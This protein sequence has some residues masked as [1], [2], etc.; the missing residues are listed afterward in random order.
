MLASHPAAVAHA[1]FFI[2][3]CVRSGTTM[4]RNLLRLHPNLA[5]PEESHF[6]R[7]SEPFAAPGYVQAN[8]QGAVLKKHREMDGISED[9]FQQM[10]GAATSRADLCERYMRRYIE[11]NKPA[12]RRWFDKTPQNAYGAA[13]I[14]CEFPQAKFVHIVRD[15]VDVVASLRIGKVI[16][17]SNLVAACAY[18]NEAAENLYVLRKAFPERVLDIRYDSFTAQPAAG[19]AR[20][21][22]FLG[23]PFE[24]ATFAEVNT[25]TI[26][27]EEGAV[28]TREEADRVRQLCRQG[29]RWHGFGDADA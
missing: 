8:S 1:P 24:P 28:L 4:L 17:I 14:A 21:L 13:M 16:K 5:C 9:A 27:H 3:G 23:E 19:L 6:F 25:Q 18:W 7:W 12:A 15:P 29:R 10:L 20:V 2:L 11:L 26:R 22:N